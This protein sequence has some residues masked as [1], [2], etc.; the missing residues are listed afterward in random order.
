[1][2]R[3][4]EETIGRERWDAFLRSYFDAHGFQSMTTAAFLGVLDTA[5]PDLAEQVKVSEWIHGQGLPPNC[6][7]PQSK[8]IEEVI[9]AANAW[10]ATGDLSS[11]DAVDWSS[12]E[13]V[14]FIEALPRIEAERM[15]ELDVHFHFSE[16]GNSEVLAAWL[17]KAAQEQYRQA[18]PAIERFLKIQGRRKFLRP[19]YEALAKNAEDLTFAQRIYAEARPTYHPV[20]QGTIDAILKE[21]TR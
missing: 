20:S 7:V 13:R 12:H 14:S 9:R 6:P 4:M 16:S 21:K 18:Y 19:I 8:A 15:G 5:F 1:M 10:V 17:R 11:L 3:L 2:L